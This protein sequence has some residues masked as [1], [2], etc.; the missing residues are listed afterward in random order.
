MIDLKHFRA[1]LCVAETGSLSRAS[2]LLRRSQPSLS[3]LIR[4]TEN[5][6]GTRLFNRTGRGMALTA[7]GEAFARAI[8]SPLAALDRAVH[9][10][11]RGR[12]LSGF[13]AIGV[14]PS[15]GP[16]LSMALT[17]AAARCHPGLSIRIIEGYPGHM[18][19]W[20]Q[21][22]ELD[23]ALIYGPA[24]HL[25]LKLTS[26]FVEPLVLIADAATGLSPDEPVPFKEL[27]RLPL[28][29]PSRPYGIRSIIDRAAAERG[30]QP[31]LHLESESGS[32]IRSMVANGMGYS[33][34]PLS[35]IQTELAQGRLTWAPLTDPGIEREIVLAEPS[36][37]PATEAIRSVAVLVAAAV[38][39]L[40]AKGDMD[41]RQSKA[42]RRL[43]TASD[44]G[45]RTLAI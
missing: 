14:P 25:H 43:A 41:I 3:Q 45:M 7:D 35:A 40:E 2:D 33:A 42:C 18:I 1:F 19:D 15:L 21:K 34:Q 11:R 27:A 26:L 13:V 23:L 16:W 39:E 36:D 12:A 37:R 6:L 38:S 28:V 29:L 30:I 10:T 5:T 22:G 8:R 44:D 17:A 32:A 24:E 9:A 31:A 4:E 20:L